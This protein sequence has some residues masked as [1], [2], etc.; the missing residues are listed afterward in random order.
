MSIPPPVPP[1]PPHPQGAAFP[2]PAPVPPYPP[3]PGRPPG[4]LITAVVLMVL[5]GL[6][7]AAA[8]IG[9]EVNADAAFE[10]AGSELARQGASVEE[11]TSFVGGG[12][13]SS[14]LLAIS[15][16]AFLALA[17]PV[18]L[19][20]RA[21]RVLA[22]VVCAQDLLCLGWIF[23]VRQAAEAGATGYDFTAVYAAIDAQ[24]PAWLHA[25]DSVWVPAGGL[26]DVAVI[27]LLAMGSVSA[28]VNARRP[29]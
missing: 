20:V 16:V 26:L 1:G 7:Y 9:A 14:V 24:Y 18:Y 23:T 15:P 11:I 29:R 12:D 22:W 8:Y 19:G 27:I 28:Y 3:P 21:A 6:A 2:V 5:M 25:L 17:F 10:A 13:L 4:A